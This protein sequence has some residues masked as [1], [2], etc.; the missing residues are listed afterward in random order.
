M[1]A[2]LESTHPAQKNVHPHLPPF[3]AGT[4][5]GPRPEGVNA[6]TGENLLPNISPMAFGSGPMQLNSVLSGQCM[7]GNALIGGP[8]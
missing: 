6:R 1:F 7:A 2:H 8:P 5:E 3:S 4:I